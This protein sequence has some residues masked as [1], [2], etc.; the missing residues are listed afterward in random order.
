MKSLTEK[1]QSWL[2]AVA[3][4]EAGEHE[5]AMEIAGIGPRPTKSPSSALNALDRTF[6]AVSFAEEGLYDEARR[7]VKFSDRSRPAEPEDFL[8]AIGLQGVRVQY[9]MARL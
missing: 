7:Y 4:A 3:F 8:D 5:S 2:A 6:V 1:I 9:V